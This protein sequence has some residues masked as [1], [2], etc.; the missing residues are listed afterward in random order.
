MTC[1]PCHKPFD[2]QYVNKMVKVSTSNVPAVLYS[3]HF[4]LAG[5]NFP[6][7]W[8]LARKVLQLLQLYV[9]FHPGTQKACIE[10]TPVSLRT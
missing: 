9:A 10:F 7:L 5:C 3:L 2:I 1:I 6:P 8:K 4:F